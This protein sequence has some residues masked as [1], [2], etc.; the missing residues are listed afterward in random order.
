MNVPAMSKDMISKNAGASVCSG[1][2]GGTEYTPIRF[3][4]PPGKVFSEGRVER[5]FD[6]LEPIFK[7]SISKIS[8][9]FG[10]MTGL[11]PR[12]P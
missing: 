6:Y 1:E 5:L 3:G 2:P 9:S 12:S 7:S 10:P 4:P 8:V 11:A